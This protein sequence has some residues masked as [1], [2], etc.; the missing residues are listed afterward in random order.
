[1]VVGIMYRWN[2]C[3]NVK[4]KF[5]LA[6]LHISTYTACKDS[7]RGEVIKLKRLACTE[8]VENT[9]KENSPIL[10]PEKKWCRNKGPSDMRSP[11]HFT[12]K[13]RHSS[14]RILAA[15][16]INIITKIQ[17]KLWIWNFHKWQHNSDMK[18]ILQIYKNYFFFVQKPFKS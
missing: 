13:P 3:I 15:P 14:K 17:H 5:I 9:E 18:L 10:L 11:I 2:K 6:E 12:N 7:K 16:V 8:V 1:M 4:K